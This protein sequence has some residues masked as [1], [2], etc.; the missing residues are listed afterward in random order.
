MNQTGKIVAAAVGGYILGRRRKFK[1]AVGIGLYLGARQLNIS[2]RMLVKGLTGELGSLPV[3]GEL[4]DQTREQLVAT[5]KDAAGKLVNKWAGGLADSLNDRTERLRGGAAG[6]ASSAAGAATGAVSGRR[7]ARDDDAPEARADHP[8]EDAEDTGAADETDEAPAAGRPARTRP[9][10]ARSGARS[11]TRKAAGA[12][13]TARKAAPRKR[14][15]KPGAA[16]RRG[17]SSEDGD[18][19]G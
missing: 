9:S 10:G 1:L 7:R 4:K 12:A 6:A 5:G 3:V 11:A 18:E 16:R 15:A 2:P 19:R 13:G 8:V 14:T 17:S